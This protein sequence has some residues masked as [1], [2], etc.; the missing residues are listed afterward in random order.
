M[1]FG[2]SKCGHEFCDLLL[3]E[4]PSHLKLDLDTKEDFTRR[5]KTPYTAKR[6]LCSKT[7]SPY[8]IHCACRAH[9]AWD[10]CVCVGGGALISL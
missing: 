10:W 9:I 7:S 3:H 4:E 1:C 5:F 8:F 2:I 6:K